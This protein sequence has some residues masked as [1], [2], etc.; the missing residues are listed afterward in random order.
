[1]TKRVTRRAKRCPY[2]KSLH[3]IKK[4]VRRDTNT[5]ITRYL[6]K[7]CGRKFQEKRRTENLQKKIFE[8]YFWNKRTLRELTEIF[9]LNRKTVQKHIHKYKIKMRK[10]KPR[11]INLIVDV[12]FFN[13]RKFH[14]E[15]GVMVFYDSLQEEVIAWRE[16]TTENLS[17]YREMY[18][19]LI[20]DGFTIQSVVID[21]KRGLQRFF[22]QEGLV[23]QYCHF[24]QIQTIL[25]YLTRNPK[26]PA[27]RQ[28]KRMTERLTDVER[29]EFTQLF[30]HYLEEW[31]DYI[32][33]KQFDLETGKYRYIHKRLRSAIAS[34]KRN[35]PY[36]F[37]YLDYPELHIKNTTNLLDGGEFAYLKR[38]LRNHNGCSK[39]LK[40][41]MI[42]EY[43]ENH[44]SKRKNRV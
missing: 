37:T 42:D 23:I 7:K 40:L 13:K 3:T 17:D 31:R 20:R 12:I 5:P 16:V 25:R 32:H 6:C 9:S 27:L 15:F 35:I 11:T 28:F 10:K 41:K 30:E 26:H 43:F 29:E 24:H 36:L 19:Q 21:G 8:E 4:G 38:L 34:L 18:F 33:E 2:C 22:E 14:T 39:E 1:M 44:K